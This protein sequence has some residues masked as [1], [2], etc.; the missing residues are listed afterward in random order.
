MNPNFPLINKSDTFCKNRK[1]LYI[2]SNDRDILKWP[3]NN[4]FEIN[5]PQTYNDVTSI[6][7]FDVQL[8]NFYFNVSEYL[9][10][11]KL[12]VTFN[13]VLTIIT[14]ED[15]Y[16]TP[17]HIANSL[18]KQF[19][20]LLDPNF[21]IIF[22]EVNNK[23]Y[24]YHPTDDFK[25]NFNE[26]LD[27]SNC[28]NNVY[29][30]HSDWGLGF[31]LGFDKK[32]YESLENLELS[33]DNYFDYQTSDWINGPPNKII[34]SEKS[35]TLENNKSIFVELY[36]YNKSDEIKPYLQSIYNN[37]NSG[38]VNSAFAKLSIYNSN[39]QYNQ[40]ILS[41]S[42]LENI[43]YYNPV[44]NSLDKLRFKFR[45]HNG[46]LVNFENHNISFA[47]EIIEKKSGI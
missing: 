35:N 26:K 30:Q 34:K 36:K 38:I 42:Y 11:N 37:N 14:L 10:T 33:N 31:L 8:P 15:G 17:Q 16:Y 18:T 29:Q 6:R 5:C 25:L 27:F 13:S 19:K 1:V 4:E 24:F 21:Y 41:N 23:F 32:T 47:L 44:I 45:Y 28:I 39:L 46:M 9:Q 20:Q 22:N 12:C 2:D 40:P 3:N 43:T 7:M